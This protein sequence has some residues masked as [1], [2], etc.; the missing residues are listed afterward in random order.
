M[1]R[2]PI[3]IVDD[4]SGLLLLLRRY[5]ERLGYDVDAADTAEEALAL[6]E[7]NPD[8]HACVLTDLTLPG[9]GGEELVERLRAIR[10]G[11]PALISSG[12]PYDPRSA[13]TGFLQKPYL[14]AMLAEA[15]ERILRP[16]RASG[17][18]PGG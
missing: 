5:L 10:P 1:S 15:I 7:S 3:L 13:A 6:F 14:P 4:E 11:L 17:S 8:R 12:Y 18:S 9:M 2:V 16:S